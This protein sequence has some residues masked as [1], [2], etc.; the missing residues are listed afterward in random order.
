MTNSADLRAGLSPIAAQELFDSL[1]PLTVD[2]MLGRWHGSE[3]PTG[4]PM[5]GMLALSGR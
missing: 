2:D 1:P 3:V 5:D 4:H